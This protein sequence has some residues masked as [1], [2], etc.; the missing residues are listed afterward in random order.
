MVLLQSKTTIMFL[1]KLKCRG[2]VTAVNIV[3]PLLHTEAIDICV[4]AQ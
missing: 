2:G 3:A 4:S 1:I